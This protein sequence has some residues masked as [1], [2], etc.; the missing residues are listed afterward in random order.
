MYHE[1]SYNLTTIILSND[2]QRQVVSWQ[3]PPS[4]SVVMRSQALAQPDLSEFKMAALQQ[5]FD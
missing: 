1:P 3:E 5:Q 2:N 4:P